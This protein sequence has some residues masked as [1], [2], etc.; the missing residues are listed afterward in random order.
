M[1]VRFC[2]SENTRSAE[3][4]SLCPPCP[5]VLC[6]NSSFVL[7]LAALLMST[8]AAQNQ[9]RQPPSPEKRIQYQIRL[10]LDYENRTYTGIERVRWVNRGDHPTSTLYFHL[11]PNVRMPAYVPPT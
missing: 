7:I 6:V 8:V 3:R 10:A 2:H 4:F 11:Y 5:R 9:N 1:S